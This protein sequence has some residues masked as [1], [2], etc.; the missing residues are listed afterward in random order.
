IFVISGLK[1]KTSDAQAATSGPGRAGFLFGVVTILFLTSLTGFVAVRIPFGV[2]EF[3]Y[4]LA[5]FRTVPTTLSSGVTLVALAGGND[6]LA[7]LLTVATNVLGVA[8]VPFLLR[9]VL[10]GGV[11]DVHIDA[12]VLLGKLIVTVLVP[13]LLGKAARERLPGAAGW[14]RR[15]KV[16]LSLTSSAMLIM[17]FWLSLS[18]SSEDVKRVAPADLLAVRQRAAIASAISLSGGLAGL[19][20]YGLKLPPRE[21]KAVVIMGSEKAPP[22]A[23]TILSYL[24]ALGNAGLMAV[25]CIIGQV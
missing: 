12:V 11:A 4:G 7:L 18:E 17:V 1:L 9:A 2:P 25:P 6:A 20:C 5:V 23:L 22:I 8:T 13:I 19:C 10:S 16:P 3:S 15:R 24:A 14:A 21:M